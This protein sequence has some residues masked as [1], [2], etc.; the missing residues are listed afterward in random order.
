M[1]DAVVIGAGHNGLV[2]ANLLVDAGWDVEV[3]EATAEAGGCVRSAELTLEGFRHDVFSAFYPVAAASPVL[4]DLR[5]EQQGLRW[6][7]AP[8]VLAHPLPDGRCA[9]LS[10]DPQQTAASLEAFAAGDGGAWLRMFERWTAIRE[11]LISA[12]FSMFPPVGAGVGLARRMR[13]RQLVRFAR[14]AL[15]SVRRMAEE[16]FRGAGGGLLLGGNAMHTDIS[17][18]APGSGLVG[19]LL[20]CLGQ[21]V[22]FP[23]PE[24]GAG[25]LTAA[26]V[27]RFEQRGGTVTYGA[28]V[29][30]IEVR[31]HRAVAV[32]TATGAVIPARRA[33][34]GAVDAVTLYRHLIG[35]EHLPAAVI[36]DLDRFQFDYATVKVDWALDGG[37][38]W[39]AT[40]ARRAGTIH[41]ADNM[42]QLT[43]AAAQLACGLVPARPLIVAGQMTTADPLRSPP[44][45]EVLWAYAHVPQRVK[46]DAAGS[47]TGA[48]TPREAEEFADRIEGRIEERAPGFRA[49]IRKRHI[50]SPPA[51]QSLNP[52]LVNGA[53][54]IGTA[55]LYQQLMFRPLPGFGRPATPVPNIFLGSASAH[56]G[57]GVHGG[58]GANA[59]RAA[60][61]H[62]QRE[63]WTSFGAR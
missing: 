26:L 28:P 6:V 31:N 25:Q 51:M 9:V 8:L 46:G 11:P 36:A 34:I 27:R 39:T 45:T 63:R 52:S 35:A 33:V 62:H 40:E 38:P 60:I 17:P 14:F 18:E 58:P 15:L 12:I 30:A 54:N 32:R 43:M 57:G 2:A 13:P 48:W 50:L 7:H 3:L 16:E 1:P 37:V 59:A 24:G 19:Y 5:L 22:G 42:D 53:V 44:G 41:L 4:R 61:R 10:R 20:C 21:D 47:I 29:A 56:P 55:N 49:R 23:V